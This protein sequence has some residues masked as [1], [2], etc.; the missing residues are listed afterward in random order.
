MTGIGAASLMGS[1]ITGVLTNDVYSDIEQECPGESCKPAL[2]ADMDRGKT[3][4]TVTNVLLI[5]GALLTVVGATLLLLDYGDLLEY[6]ESN[7]S[8][9][10][11]NR[12]A[13]TPTCDL[14][15][16]SLMAIGVF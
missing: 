10:G 5:S 2:D 13:I 6:R 14:G 16:C 3:L 9:A 1:I 8:I 15:S 7:D 11:I 4:Q 12:I